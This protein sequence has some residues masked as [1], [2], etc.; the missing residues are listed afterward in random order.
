[1]TPIPTPIVKNE[2]GR[3]VDGFDELATSPLSL[4]IEE[5]AVRFEQYCS[6]AQSK[7]RQFF[8]EELAQQ[9]R[10]AAALEIIAEPSHLQERTALREA[11][12]RGARWLKDLCDSL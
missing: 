9:F 3:L 5:L 12:D 2:L 10:A 6:Q 1:M 11:A 7:I 8:G 4:K